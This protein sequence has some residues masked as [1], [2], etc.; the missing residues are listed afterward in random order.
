MKTCLFITVAIQVWSQHSLNQHFADKKCF[1]LATTRRPLL[2]IYL[3]T[4][5]CASLLFSPHL[6]VD[7]SPHRL[8]LA[9]SLTPHLLL[10]A[11]PAALPLLWSLIHRLPSAWE[12][13]HSF[14][15]SLNRCVVL[16]SL[17]RPFIAMVP[18]LHHFSSDSAT[19]PYLR[20]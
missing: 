15:A 20:A 2:T 19:P 13:C 11:S 3:C 9:S 17:S 1:S 4:F 10:G 8:R 12:P 18:P 7:A 6:I 14:F 16:L 5:L